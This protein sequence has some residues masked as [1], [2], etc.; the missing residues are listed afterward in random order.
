MAIKVR[1][2]FIFNS[3]KINKADLRLKIGAFVIE[4]FCF[5]KTC[6]W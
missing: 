6:F 3:S 5:I 1:I 4:Y 2:S